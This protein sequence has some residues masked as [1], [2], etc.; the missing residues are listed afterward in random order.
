ME[1]WIA[2]FSAY[3]GYE[4]L[5]ENDKRNVAQHRFFIREIVKGWNRLDEPTQ[6]EFIAGRIVP[7][8]LA[9]QLA[10]VRKGKRN[11]S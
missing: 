8:T 9:L 1:D 7:S 10:E 11:G 4:T 6:E 2:R 5:S 3:L